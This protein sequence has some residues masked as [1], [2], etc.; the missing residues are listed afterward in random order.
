MAMHWDG[1]VIFVGASA[2]ALDSRPFRYI[3]RHQM[4]S[5]G[6]VL[7]TEA[8]ATTYRYGGLHLDLVGFEEEVDCAIFVI[9][10]AGTSGIRRLCVAGRLNEMYKKMNMG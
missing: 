5:K 3:D 2:K 8:L 6:K 1:C 10:Q 4:G 9:V 7:A